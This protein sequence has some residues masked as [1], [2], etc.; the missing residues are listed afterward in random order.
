M[1]QFSQLEQ[2]SIIRN[3]VIAPNMTI[4]AKE[5]L[6]L[7]LDEFFPSAGKYQIKLVVRDATRSHAVESNTVE[8]EIREP[9]GSNRD[10]Y[11]FVR[12][13]GFAESLFT[14][15]RFNIVRSILEQVQTRFPNS[16]YAKNAIFVL[17]EKH[18]IRGELRKALQHLIRLEHDNDF[19]FAERVR[20]Y[21]AKIR[22]LL[23]AQSP[24]SRNIPSQEGISSRPIE[25]DFV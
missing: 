11:N 17:G 5:W 9:N 15:D 4:E 8:I 21:L 13:S 19:F 18:F 1:S 16:P 10:A 3:F 14:G 25:F 23:T 2:Y 7:G 6:V 22:E 12:S 20:T 24:H